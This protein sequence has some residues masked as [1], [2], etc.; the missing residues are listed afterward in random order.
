MR[1]LGPAVQGHSAVAYVDR[2][3]ELLAEALHRPAQEVRRED[4][5]A[6]DHAGCAGRK[7]G[8]DRLLGAVAAARLY[9]NTG[10]RGGDALD[11]AGRGLAREGP[12][13]IDEVEEPRAFAGEPRCRL[14]R[15]AA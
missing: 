15:L 14:G 9:R 13:E 11:E 7:S 10:R 6:D 2:D 1:I 5:R 4:G 12:V 3:H 8:L